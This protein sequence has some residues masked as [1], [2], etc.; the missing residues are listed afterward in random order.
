M[1]PATVGEEKA[2]NP[3]LRAPTL[4]GRMGLEGRPDP[5]VFL[6]VRRAKDSFKG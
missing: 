5:E 2:T 1:R 4:A 6:A 3:F